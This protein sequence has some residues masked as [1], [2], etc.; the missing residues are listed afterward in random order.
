V[1]RFEADLVTVLCVFLMRVLLFRAFGLN[2]CVCVCCR[3]CG[4]V[5]C[6]GLVLM[7]CFCACAIPLCVF[8]LFLL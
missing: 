4:C 2:P 8:R 3:G 5:G 6:E 7:L 1:R